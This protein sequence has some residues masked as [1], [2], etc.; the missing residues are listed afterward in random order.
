MAVYTEVSDLELTGFLTQYDLGEVTSFKGIAEGVENSNF[1]LRTTLGIYILTLYEKRVLLEDLPFFLGLMHHLSD[2]GFACPLPVA[3]KD[4]R[5]Q[6]KARRASTC[7]RIGPTGACMLGTTSG[8]RPFRRESP[9]LTSARKNAR[10][11]VSYF[12]SGRNEPS[13]R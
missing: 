1:L 9:Y 7:P 5:Y 11:A 8:A 4:G 3:G 6:T 13:R 2:R 12:L 10:P